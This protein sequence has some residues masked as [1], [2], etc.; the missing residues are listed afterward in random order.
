MTKREIMSTYQKF[1]QKGKLEGKS[2][3]VI[4][5]HET[6]MDIDFIVKVTGLSKK[7]VE[8][9]ILEEEKGK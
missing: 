6:G 9:I 1:I 8:E 4:N 2:E 7:I 5:L 3:I